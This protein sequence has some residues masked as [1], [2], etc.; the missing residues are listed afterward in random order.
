MSEQCPKC[1][2]FDD[3]FHVCYP[4]PASAEPREPFM[5]C[6]KCKL[7]FCQCAEPTPLGQALL[8]AAD[9]AIAYHGHEPAAPDNYQNG[10]Y[11]EY[12]GREWWISNPPKIGCGFKGPTF[13]GDVHVIEKSAYDALKAAYDDWQDVHGSA[14]AHMARL[15]RE[16]DEKEFTIQNTFNH[17]QKAMQERDEA[18]AEVDRLREGL[19]A[20]T[21]KSCTRWLTERDRYKAAL[22]QI[23][24]TPGLGGLDHTSTKAWRESSMRIIDKIAREALSPK[25]ET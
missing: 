21:V 25:E 6:P 18:R 5:S 23:K 11:L 15:T 13:R 14:E 2:L 4:T 7:V 17:W 20:Q 12:V 10:K 8:D 3:G 22:E 24:D 16:R 1:G 9:D 19:D